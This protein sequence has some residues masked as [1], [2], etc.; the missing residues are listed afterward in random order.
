MSSRTRRQASR[1]FLDFFMDWLGT[2]REGF[3]GSGEQLTAALEQY[4]AAR[5]SLMKVPSG[6][7]GM[8][9]VLKANLNAIRN[10]GFRVE[11]AN[12]DSITLARR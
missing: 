10:A 12:S 9:S 3:T 1:R 4:N 8:W 6:R 11:L 7:G 5:G 2:V